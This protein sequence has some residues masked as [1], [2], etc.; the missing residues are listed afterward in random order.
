MHTQVCGCAG[1]R[2]DVCVCVCVHVCVCMCERDRNKEGEAVG[3]FPASSHNVTSSEKKLKKY[4]SSD[5]Y[6]SLSCTD[7]FKYISFKIKNTSI[8][9]CMCRFFI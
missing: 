4:T 6:C 9:S 1:A 5:E 3:I 7:I 8:F 2:L